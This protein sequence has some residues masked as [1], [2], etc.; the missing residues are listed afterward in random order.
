MNQFN[1]IN[2]LPNSDEENKIIKA[3]VDYAGL[4][5]QAWERLGQIT[6]KNATKLMKGCYSKGARVKFVSTDSGDTIY[7]TIT[8]V[9]KVTVSVQQIESTWNEWNVPPNMLEIIYENSEWVKAKKEAKV[10][11][12]QALD[13][14]LPKSL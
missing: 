3:I 10:K 1:I 11:K 5:I 2:E 6:S 9:N 7:G 13:Y 12:E 14:D 8:K 4:N